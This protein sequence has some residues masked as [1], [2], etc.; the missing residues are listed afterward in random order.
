WAECADV[1][2]FPRGDASLPS[3]LSVLS[4]IIEKSARTVIAHGLADSILI[5]EGS[6][7]VSRFYL[8]PE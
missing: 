4:N 2:V 1:R 7:G 6:R 3:A 5:A 8:V